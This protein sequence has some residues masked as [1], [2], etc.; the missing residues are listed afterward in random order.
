MPTAIAMLLSRE[1]NQVLL[2]PDVI[3]LLEAQGFE[4]KGSTPEQLNTLIAHELS[5]WRR[6]VNEGAIAQE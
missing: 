5:E 2:R 3:K 1:V 4:A 6:M